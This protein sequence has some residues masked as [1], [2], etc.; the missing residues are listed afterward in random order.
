MFVFKCTPFSPECYS[1]GIGLQMHLYTLVFLKTLCLQL[2]PKSILM[3][4]E[5]HQTCNLLTIIV[6]TAFYVGKSIG[7]FVYRRLPEE[8]IPWHSRASQFLPNHASSLFQRQLSEKVMESQLQKH[9]KFRAA[10]LWEESSVRTKLPVG[11][12]AYLPRWLMT[13]GLF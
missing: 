12:D 11:W 3:T 2:Q 7:L 10:P 5:K 13:Q 8:T 4:E 1:V 6:N 9:F